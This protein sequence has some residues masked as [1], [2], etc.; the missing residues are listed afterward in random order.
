[1]LDTAT[2]SQL[3]HL[4]HHDAFIRTSICYLHLRESGESGIVSRAGT[5]FVLVCGR[6]VCARRSPSG[7]KAR[8]S[9]SG[10]TAWLEPCPS[11]RNRVP[12]QRLKPCLASDLTAWLKPCPS[13]KSRARREVWFKPRPSESRSLSLPSSSPTS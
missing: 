11:E 13:E 10:R 2:G 3:R 12:P 1:M 8:F 7:A 4:L 9:W 6:Q 5:I